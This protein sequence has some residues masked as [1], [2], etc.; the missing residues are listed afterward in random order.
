MRIKLL[1][2]LG[3]N[4]PE[5]AKEDGDVDL[6]VLHKEPQPVEAAVLDVPDITARWLIKH[7][8]AEAPPPEDPGKAAGHAQPGR[9]HGP[10]RER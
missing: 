1:R 3:K 8:L 6:V 2:S 7:G 5:V 4:L 10:A 9:T